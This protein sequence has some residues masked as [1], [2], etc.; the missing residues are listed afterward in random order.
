LRRWVEATLRRRPSLQQRPSA[1]VH[2]G[3]CAATLTHTVSRKSGSRFG[4]VSGR[5]VMVES[6]QTTVTNL[7][8]EL[9][10]GNRGALGE[11]FPLVYAEL[12]MLAHRQRQR[13]RGDFTLNTTALVHEGYLK[14]G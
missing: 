6:T 4:A 5:T 7:L 12:L 8:R 1:R 11:L 3:R 14:R 10:T 13:W 9:Q 2:S